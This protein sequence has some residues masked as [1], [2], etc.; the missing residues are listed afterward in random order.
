MGIQ[1]NIRSIIFI[2]LW[3]LAGAGIIVLLIAAMNSRKEQVCKGYAI[4]IKGFSEDHSF[5]DKKDIENVLTINRTLSLKN[6]PIESIDLNKIEGRLKKELWVKDAELYFDNNNYLKVKVTER[7]PIARIF[8]SNGES[9]Y[10]DSTGQKLPLSVKMSAKLPVFTGFPYSGKK[11]NPSL[12][13][14]MVRQVK[15]LSFFL[16]KDPFWMAQIAQMDITPSKEFE[17]VP[18][19][20]N[21]L[22]EFGD[23]KNI[24][25]K[26]HRLFIFYTQVLAKTGMEKYERIKVQYDRQVIGVKKQHTNN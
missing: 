8:A 22:I 24:E 9:F 19:I 10:I 2:C 5:I 12:D 20:G 23:S 14:K 26:F 15:E 16:L 3:L 1:N 7:E 18:T 11:S 17:M 25:E 4:D 21:H 6:K 13:R